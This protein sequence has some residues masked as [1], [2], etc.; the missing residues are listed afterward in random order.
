MAVAVTVAFSFSVPQASAAPTPVISVSAQVD[1]NGLYVYG[2]MFD[3]SGAG[4]SSMAL[5]VSCTG[6]GSTTV[7]T[8]SD[9]SFAAVLPRPSHGSHTVRVTWNGDANYNATT[10]STHVNVQKETKSQSSL[11]VA[12]DPAQ[13]LPGTAVF[14]KG[15]LSSGTRPIASAIVNLTS[16]FGDFTTSVGTD[17]NGAFEAT[18]PLP[19]ATKPPGSFTV[20][21]S[22]NGDNIYTASSAK[23]SASV[24][25]PPTPTPTPTGTP[26]ATATPTSKSSTANPGGQPT[27]VGPE[28][29]GTKADTSRL[30]IVGIIFFGV[31]FVAVGALLVLGIISH[32]RNALED[33]ERRGFGTDFGKEDVTDTP[34][35]R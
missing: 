24:I 13:A 19:A 20:T 23:V 33:D 26:T 2:S 10:G 4:I 21:A 11:T 31:A 12:I 18:I 22:F 27:L 5:N 17:G 1:A 6:G 8:A 29:E 15:K 3:P 16:D 30:L 35:G 9:G 34:R 32:T 25:T 7:V 28:N 14:V